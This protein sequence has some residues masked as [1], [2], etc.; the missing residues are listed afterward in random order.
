MNAKPRIILVARYYIIEPLGLLYLAGLAT[1]LGWEVDVEL[2]P[3]NDFTVLYRR[4]AEWKPDFVGFQIWTGWHLQTFAACDRVRAMGPRVIIG[5]PHATYFTDEC[6]KHAD[7]V[8]RGEAFRTLRR[9]LEGELEPGIH[10][11]GEQLAEGFPMPNREIVYR[12][13]PVLRESP[14]RSIITSLGCPYACSYCYAPEWNKMYSGFDHHQRSVDE[15]VAEG[16]EIRDRWGARMIYFQDDI[17]GY[18]M[19]WLPE[20]AER[21]PREVGI[22]WHCQI[23]LELTRHATGDRRLDLLK[24]GGCTGITLAIEAGDAFMREH[25]LNRPMPEG[26]ILEGCAKIKN[27]GMTLRLEQIL[28]I[29]FSTLETDLAT[30]RLNNIINPEMAWTSILA[31]Y[32]GTLMGDISSNFGFYRG[33]NDDLHQLFFDRSVLRHSED[34]RRVIEPVVRSIESRRM[35]S[36]LRRM[37]GVEV[38]PSVV[39]VRMKDDRDEFSKRHLPGPSALCRFRFLSDKD[40]EEYADRTVVLQR[41]FM[42]FSLVH[43]GDRLAK[44]FVTLPR[45]CWT[46]KV[47]GRMTREFFED[48]GYGDDA[49][50]SVLEL[51]RAMGY[52][53]HD[54]FPEVVGANP[55]YFVYFPSSAEFARHVAQSGA[56]DMTAPPGQQFEELGGVARRWLFERSLY[57]IVPSTPP[58]ARRE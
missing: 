46:W 27:R 55:Y 23:R 14:I 41:L 8:A 2:V 32:G 57:K 3:D 9:I 1:S 56:V 24:R 53:S 40:N 50:R 12:K 26:L 49:K 45:E 54:G 18:N 47:L 58:I 34:A 29:P 28:A 5:G 35:D 20:F 31:P 33:N 4:V 15:L 25:V 42:W 6:G 30:L 17:F 10:F 19:A 22:P 43:H 44:A 16:R 13:Y 51:A 37:V 11:D 52:G 48:S 38:E 36:P 39:E 7:F 21:W